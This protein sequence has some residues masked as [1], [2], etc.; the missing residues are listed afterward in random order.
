VHTLAAARSQASTL[1]ELTGWLR[2]APCCQCS[3]FPQ[4]E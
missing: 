4:G 1:L 2:E 3:G